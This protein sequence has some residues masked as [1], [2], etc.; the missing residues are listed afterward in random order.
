[1][2]ILST[3]TDPESIAMFLPRREQNLETHR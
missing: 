2:A 1:M 3:K